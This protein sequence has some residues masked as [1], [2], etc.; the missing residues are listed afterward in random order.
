[1]SP[2]GDLVSTASNVGNN[3]SSY[4]VAVNIDPALAA[5]LKA[6][7]YLAGLFITRSYNVSNS[8]TGCAIQPI[9]ME[10]I[11]SVIPL[12]LTN[13][14]TTVLDTAA[15]SAVPSTSSTLAAGNSSGSA[16]I[17]PDNAYVFV[18]LF[19]KRTGGTPPPPLPV[20]QQ[21]TLIANT[22]TTVTPQAGNTVAGKQTATVTL[23]RTC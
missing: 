8:F 20:D 23:S 17:Q 13:L 16:Q 7:G 10:H 3:A 12:D 14:Q 6:K 1:M 11:I 9:P 21:Q 19:G 4:S 22:T 2:V 5:Q 15:F 18:R